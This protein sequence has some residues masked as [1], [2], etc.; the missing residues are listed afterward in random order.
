[1]PDYAAFSTEIA[2]VTTSG[3]NSASYTPS[4]TALQSCPTVDAN[5]AAAASPLPPTPNQ[6]LCSC[7]LPTL[8]CVLNNSTDPSKYGQLFNQLYGYNGGQAVAGIVANATTGVYGAYSM[9]DAAHQLSFA[10]NAYFLEQQAAGNGASA[11]DFGGAATTQSSA[12]PSGT[13][14]SLVQQAGTAGTN[15]VSAVATGGSAA[16][17]STSKGVA[18]PMNAPRAVV[19]GSWQLGAYVV[20]ALLSGGF[21]VWL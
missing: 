18:Y 2:T 3:V 14:A 17:T 11:C 10:F 16:S 6:Q 21:M 12:A 7:M 5:W 1:M 20:V 13:C 19:V 8:Q 9:C 15:S 4:N